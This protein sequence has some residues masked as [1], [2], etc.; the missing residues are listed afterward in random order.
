VRQG[1]WLAQQLPAGMLEDEFLVRFVRIFQGV[2]DTV[3]D[4]IDTLAFQFDPR[5][6]PPS[7][8][9]QLGR[10]LGLRVDSAADPD[11]QRRLVVVGARELPWRGTE[12]CIRALV[13][14]ITG[15][16]PIVIS[17]SG[18]VYGEDDLTVWGRPPH[19]VIRVSDP[20]IM[21]AS[22]LAH[23]IRSELPATT[24]LELYVAGDLVWPEPEWVP[25]VPEIE[26]QVA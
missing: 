3:F 15:C 10:W 11:I 18:G 19:V 12:R 20:G 16:G 2:A 25:D 4:Q 24:T 14:V 22:D 7:M 8:V 21:S 1:D 26:E 6:A 5:T 9:R 17:D 23:F 13:E